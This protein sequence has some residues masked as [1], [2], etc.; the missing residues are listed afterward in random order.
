LNLSLEILSIST[1][2]TITARE[3][4]KIDDSLTTAK[5][6]TDDDILEE[7]LIAEGIIDPL[8]VL[9]KISGPNFFSKP[10]LVWAIWASQLFL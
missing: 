10:K 6:L 8:Q 7:I 5:I 3:Y 4:I 2:V 1:S 9:I